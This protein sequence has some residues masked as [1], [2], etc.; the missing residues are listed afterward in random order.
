MTNQSPEQ[1]RALAELM[2][3]RSTAFGVWTELTDEQSKAINIALTQAAKAEEQ[4]AAIRD[5]S[6]QLRSSIKPDGQLYADALD[7]ILGP[8]EK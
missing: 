3:H 6:R 8:L 7:A 1:L 2:N 5:V 4:L